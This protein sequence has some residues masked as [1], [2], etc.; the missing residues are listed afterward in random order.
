MAKPIKMA[1]FVARPIT[2]DF[3]CL[4]AGMRHSAEQG[5]IHP[6]TGQP[7]P[8][9]CDFALAAYMLAAA[10]IETFVQE[11]FLSDIA[12]SLFHDS[13]LFEAPEL[14]RLQLVEKL[15]LFPRLAFG[16]KV[17]KGKAPFQDAILLVK[18]RNALMH[19]KV[20]WEDPEATKILVGMDSR[21]LLVPDPEDQMS[22]KERVATLQGID[23]AHR[24]AVETIKALIR[25][26]PEKHRHHFES[27]YGTQFFMK[28]KT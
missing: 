23:W 15:T 7:S 16:A 1:N 19:Y 27:A 8:P 14:D 5:R 13:P 6:K 17:D 26:I 10:S 9:F 21:K 18:L 2:A 11:L 24:T 20:R 4:V 12:E 25:F 22:W 3:L 28:P